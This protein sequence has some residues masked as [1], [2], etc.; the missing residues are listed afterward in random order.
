MVEMRNACRI[1]VRVSRECAHLASLG[2][3]A[4]KVADGW[5]NL[6]WCP[7]GGHQL[8]DLAN[9]VLFNTTVIHSK[10]VCG[11]GGRFHAFVTSALSGK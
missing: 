9:T 5:N 2:I 1:S 7:T 3:I 11:C 10:N 6:R 8:S 4:V